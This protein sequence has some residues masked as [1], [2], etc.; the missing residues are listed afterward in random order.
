MSKEST[1]FKRLSTQM[2][3]PKL[4]AYY[5]SALVGAVNRASD[6]HVRVVEAQT[7]DIGKWLSVIAL[8]VSTPTDNSAE[9]KKQMAILEQATAELETAVKANQP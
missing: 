9:V 2:S 8:A 5:L 4:Q 1:E 7:K 3:G 6:A